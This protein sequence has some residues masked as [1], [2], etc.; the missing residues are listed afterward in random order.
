MENRTTPFKIG[1][2]INLQELLRVFS[3]IVDLF[4]LFMWLIR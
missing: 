4:T 2:E 3:L 1:H